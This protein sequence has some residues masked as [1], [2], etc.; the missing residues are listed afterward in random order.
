MNFKKTILSA[1]ATLFLVSPVLAELVFPSL[2]YRTGA[3]G[4]NGIPFADGY[5]DYF[6]LM[7]E[8]DGGIGGEKVRV[9]KCETAYNTEKGVE[10]Y[11]STKGE[12]ALLYLSLIHI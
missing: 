6:T 10:C 3:Y 11:E 2:S 4:P 1:L 12:G 9:V 7:N 8:R 5:E